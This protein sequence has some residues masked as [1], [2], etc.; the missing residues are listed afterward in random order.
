MTRRGLAFGIALSIYGREEEVDT[1]IEQMTQDQDPI[2][3][4]GDM[5]ALTLAYNGTTNKKAI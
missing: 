2:F 5:Y 4:Y 1:L 3:P